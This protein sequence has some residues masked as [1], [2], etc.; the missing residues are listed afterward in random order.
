METDI[1]LSAGTLA[2]AVNRHWRPNVNAIPLNYARVGTPAPVE[3]VLLTRLPTIAQWHQAKAALLRANIQCRMGDG[4][5][6][7]AAGGIGMIVM[8]SD[9]PRA[10]RVLEFVKSG[11]NW[12]PRCGCKSLRVLPM[13]GW[14]LFLATV[15]LGVP[16]FE[17]RRFEC[18]NCGHQW[19]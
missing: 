15:F 10:I 14:W 18:E 6:N 1:P 11:A 17:P 4:E 8:S 2:D 3:W 13:P 5:E 12:C 16:P 7:D 9:V 19:K